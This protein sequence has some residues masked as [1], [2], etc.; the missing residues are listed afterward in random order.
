M[1]THSPPVGE[2]EPTLGMNVVPADQFSFQELADAYNQTR[3]DYIVPMPMTVERLVE[4]VRVYDVDLS[5]SC[6]AVINDEIVGIG[7]LGLREER[8]WITRLGVT[9]AGRRKGT[10]GHIMDFLVQKS[11]EH[12]IAEMWLEVIQGNTPAHTLFRK[13]GFVEIDELIV[14]RRPP[15]YE[16]G[17]ASAAERH[18]IKDVKTLT[19]SEAILLLEERCGHQAW[20]NQIESL[21]NVTELTGILLETDDGGQGWVTFQAS[22]MQLKRVIVE[23]R[24]GDAAKVSAALLTVLHRLYPTQDAIAENFSVHDP[25]WQGFQEAGYFDAFRRIEMIKDLRSDY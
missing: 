24:R 12:E 1:I 22:L 21:H 19:H 20:T 23:V 5:C 13:N 10:G 11:L 25:I 7:M 18:I 9:P 16:A 8:S 4:Y 6:A 14:A 15:K 2:N 17:T 3:I